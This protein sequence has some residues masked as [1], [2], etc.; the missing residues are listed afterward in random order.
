MHIFTA[1]IKDHEVVK[2]L[3]S[4][5]VSLDESDTE[6]RDELVQE[7]R[8]NL[9]PH[10]RAEESVFYN[11][12][13]ALDT[14][15]DVVMHGFREHMEAEALLRLL[16]V[17]DKLN[18]GW[19]NTAKKLKHAVEHHIQEEEGKIF[20]TARHVISKEEGETLGDLFEKVK[21]QI[22]EEGF[23]K[24]SF[25]MVVNMMPVRFATAIKNMGTS[26]KA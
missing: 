26:Q 23:M 19:K 9:V 18:L 7:I 25:D 8:D 20:A 13:R 3:L 22:E 15:K 2:E 1:L 10:A 5:L 12:L 11:S 6:A 17:E 21:P 14:N 16:Q 4:E 24:N